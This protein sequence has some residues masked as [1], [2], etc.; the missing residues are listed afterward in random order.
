MI[1]I[2]L[3]VNSEFVD[4]MDNIENV[5]HSCDFNHIIRGDFNTSFFLRVMYNQNVYHI[6]LVRNN[7]LTPQQH[8]V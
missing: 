1:L 5:L 7:L 4:C 8:Y 6:F 2:W 3:T